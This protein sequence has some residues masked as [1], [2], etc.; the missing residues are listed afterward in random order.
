MR[1]AVLG[2]ADAGPFFTLRKFNFLGHLDDILVYSA[3]K[4]GFAGQKQKLIN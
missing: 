2:S 4:A 3:G 1:G